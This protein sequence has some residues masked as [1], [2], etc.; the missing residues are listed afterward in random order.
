MKNISK[1]IIFFGSGPLAAESLRQISKD[2]IVEH[3]ITKPRPQHHRYPAPVEI[4]AQELGINVLYANS[5]D[6]VDNVLR[7][8]DFKSRVGL[9]IDF[10]VIVSEFAIN[11][12]EKGIIN[13]HFSLLPRWRGADPITYCLLKGDV[14]T[15]VSLMKIVPKLD[16]GPLIAQES[17]K[18]DDKINAIDLTRLLIDQSNSMIKKYLPEFVAGS[19]NPTPQPDITPT[20][21]HKV[22]KSDG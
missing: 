8:M 11:R 18:L 14:Q 9:I 3:V 20:Y 21:S 5:K 10:G 7:D 19:L 6:E 12:F 2:F 22:K 1:T 13:S 4:L 16:E 17:F 15:G